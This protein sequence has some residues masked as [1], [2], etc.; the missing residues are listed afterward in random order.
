MLQ[1]SVLV[2]L[3]VDFDFLLSAGCVKKK[4]NVLA[5]WMDPFFGDTAGPRVLL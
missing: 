5:F 4:S 2:C 1:M 3:C